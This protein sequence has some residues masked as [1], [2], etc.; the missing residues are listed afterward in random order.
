[1]PTV[2]WSITLYNNKLFSKN[3]QFVPC[4]PTLSAKKKF[5]STLKV[6]VPSSAVSIISQ[7]SYMNTDLQKLVVELNVREFPDYYQSNYAL[8]EINVPGGGAP[9]YYYWVDN[10]RYINIVNEDGAPAGFGF[11]QAE[12]TLSKDIWQ[13]EF[14]KEEYRNDTGWTLAMPEIT[15][16]VLERT[17]NPHFLNKFPNVAPRNN[18]PNSFSSTNIKKVML[19]GNNVRIVAIASLSHQILSSLNLPLYLNITSDR[20]YNLAVNEDVWELLQDIAEINSTQSLMVA[21]DIPGYN[22]LKPAATIQ[23]A[24]VKTYIIPEGFIPLDFVFGAY[25]TYRVAIKTDRGT[26]S[27]GVAQRSIRKIFDIPTINLNL[28]DTLSAFVIGTEKQ[29]QLLCVSASVITA[30][31]LNGN[32]G[33]YALRTSYPISVEFSVVGD[34][35][36]IVIGTQGSNG[37]INC[38]EDLST[39]FSFSEEGNLRRQAAQQQ[40]T[41]AILGILTSLVSSGVAIASGNPAAMILAGTSTAQS[42]VSSSNTIE[43]SQQAYEQAKKIPS[44]AGEVSSKLYSA[45]SSIFIKYEQLDNEQSMQNIMNT[46]GAAVSLPLLSYEKNDILSTKYIFD[47]SDYPK[48]DLQYS[49]HKATIEMSGIATDYIDYVKMRFAQGFQFVYFA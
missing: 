14:F 25:N 29:N 32:I 24:I 11:M 45:L 40:E 44:V 19:G 23:A 16:G 8:I 31:I 2:L 18:N 33:N 7:N 1:M 5:E 34:Y 12:L 38:A 36:S 17:T 22:G 28:P 47:I 41:N 6:T 30:G 13:S 20:N 21:T 4:C 42:L 43:M 46:F 15:G 26:Q 48:T 3:G 9:R 49:Y 35:C 27:H 37:Q 39:P 10:I